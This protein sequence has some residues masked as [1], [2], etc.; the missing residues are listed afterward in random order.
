LK[1]LLSIALLAVVLP[2]VAVAGN[3]KSQ[4][5]D[6]RAEQLTKKL[7]L[8]SEQQEKAR[9]ILMDAQTQN[10]ALAKKYKLDAYQAE[11]QEVNDASQKAISD[12]LT[13]EQREKFEAMKK[14]KKQKK[15]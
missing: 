10:E 3:N 9:S 6:H 14:S 8:S 11:T 13:P 1:N 5:P 15:K 4:D 12:M 2:V 7:D